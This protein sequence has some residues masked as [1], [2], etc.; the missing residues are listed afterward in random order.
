MCPDDGLRC[1]VLYAQH[2]KFLFYYDGSKM[3]L[4][5]DTVTEC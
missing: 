3:V 2:S 5:G 4:T 1:L